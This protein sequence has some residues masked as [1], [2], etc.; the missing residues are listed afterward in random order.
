VYMYLITK[1]K[2][3]EKWLWK[4]CFMG[5]S[6]TEK[7]CPHPTPPLTMTIHQYCDALRPIIL[8]HVS[9]LKSRNL[10]EEF[11]AFLLH[12]HSEINRWLYFYRPMFPTYL[13]TTPLWQIPRSTFL[14]FRQLRPVFILWH[15]PNIRTRQR[16]SRVCHIE[17]DWAAKVDNDIW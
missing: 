7:G 11:T 15:G 2:T 5:S 12:S 17:H 13:T 16:T 14:L 6:R 8:A 3:R 10:L 9:S 1:E 4:Y